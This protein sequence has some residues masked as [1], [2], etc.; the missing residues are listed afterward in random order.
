MKCS[1]PGACIQSLAHCARLIDCLV[2][3][4]FLEKWAYLT[5]SLMSR[6]CLSKYITPITGLDNRCVQAFAFVRF[7]SY[8]SAL[9]HKLQLSPS[10]PKFLGTGRV[11]QVPIPG[12]LH[13]SLGACSYTVSSVRDNATA[14]KSRRQPV[15]DYT[16][17][18]VKHLGV[19]S[20]DTYTDS[21]SFTLEGFTLA[22]SI[23]FLTYYSYDFLPAFRCSLPCITSCLWKA[24]S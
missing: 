12:L 7:F 22:A 13:P 16:L 15:R 17:A 20:Y 23:I 21:F 18:G 11:Y 19:C 4:Q 10:L 9:Q 6:V 8:S 1:V 2:V 24:L 14:S 3:L 5:V